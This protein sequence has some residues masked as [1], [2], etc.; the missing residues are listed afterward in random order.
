MELGNKVFQWSIDIDFYHLMLK[1]NKK[2]GFFAGESGKSQ[3]SFAPK[4]CV[5]EKKAAI[6]NLKNK[7]YQQ[8]A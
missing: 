5:Y 2:T 4:I 1:N 7:V 6:E 3:Y 8:S